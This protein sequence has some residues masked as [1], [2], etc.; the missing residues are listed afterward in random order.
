[1][2]EV[3][4][5]VGRPITIDGVSHTVIGVLPPGVDDL[6]AIRASAWTALVMATPTRRGPFGIRGFARLREGVTLE[7][8]AADLAGIS[9]RIFP[10]WSTGNRDSTAKY[11]PIP[12]REAIVGTANRQIGLFAAAVVLVL[13]VAVANVATLLLVRSSARVQELSVRIALG[14]GR[15][16]LGRLVASEGVVL[17]LLAGLTGLGIAWSGVRLVTAIAPTLPRIGEV[18]L[19]FRGMGMVLVLALVSGILVNISPVAAALSGRGTGSLRADARRA[20]TSRRTNALRGALVVGVFALALPLLLGA[21]LL[22]N[23]FLRLQRVDPGFNPEGA[24]SVRLTLPPARYPDDAAI[25]KF[26]RQVLA[27]VEELPVFSA[28]GLMSDLPPD[29]QG[30]TNNFDLVD[31]PVPAGTA[32]YIAPWSG[33]SPGYFRVLGIPLLEGRLFTEADSAS[34]P[35]VVLVSRTWA[36]KYFAGESALGKRLI[37]GGCDT[38]ARTTVIGVV[39]DVKYSGMAGDGDGVYSPFTQ[40]TPNTMHLVARSRVGPGEAFAALRRELGAIDP[41]LPVTEAVLSQRVH[42]SLADPRRW[43]TVLGAFAGA[44]LALAAL[45]IFGL[46]SYTVRQRRR[47]IG[48]RLALGAEPAMVTRMIVGRGMRYALIGTTIGFAVSVVEARWLRSLL[49]DVQASDP[50][51]LTGSALVLLL[52]ALCACWVPGWRAARIRPVEAM[53]A[54]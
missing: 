13:L 53:Q 46:M 10:L 14:A 35:P 25:Q 32:E 51:T 3:A 49:Y 45:G 48:V 29:T 28:V 11:V 21:G 1:M 16:R 20:G 52:A 43:T 12:L 4:R 24:I 36:T 22:L 37:S 6:A 44:A 50:V 34:A 41:E 54:E 31:K 18:T 26:W 7:A 39:G 15:S 17:T 5:A 27:R 47:E 19:G 30:Q 40:F 42:A 9:E 23:S 33:A 2:G 38:C 8:A